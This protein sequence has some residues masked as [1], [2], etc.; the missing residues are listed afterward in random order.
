VITIGAR[1][2]LV[3]RDATWRE[4][5]RVAEDGAVLVRPDHHVAWRSPGAAP[6]P[7]AALR[8]AFEVVLPI[9]TRVAA[10]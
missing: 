8:E 1:T 6:D 9:G 4:Q 2:G 7:L 3:D 5:S 10:V